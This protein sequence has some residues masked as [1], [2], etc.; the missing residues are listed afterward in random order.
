MM[1]TISV[2][3]LSDYEDETDEIFWLDLSNANPIP[4]GI[5]TTKATIH[6]TY[7]DVPLY[8]VFLPLIS[9]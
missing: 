1:K 3:V 7:N 9:R 4:L 6:N 5:T 8:A 2:T